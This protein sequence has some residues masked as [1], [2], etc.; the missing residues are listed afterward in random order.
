VTAVAGVTPRAT[1]MAR[2]MQCATTVA[3]VVKRG[4]HRFVFAPFEPS[5]GILGSSGSG[6]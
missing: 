4:S 2:V 3:R 1:T 5:A 6:K